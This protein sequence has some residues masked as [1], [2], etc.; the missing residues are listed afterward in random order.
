M[1]IYEYQ[2]D[3]CGH[4]LEA[5]QRIVDK[6]LRKCPDCGKAK[7]K[8]QLSAPMFLLKGSGW[9]ETD[10]KSDKENRRNLADRP[11]KEEPKAET[12][13]PAKAETKAEAKVETP[14]DSTP[15][16]KDAAKPVP[17]KKRTRPQGLRK[18]KRRRT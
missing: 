5:L 17:E 7:L 1:P 18:A 13:A 14:A 16:A 2:C 3:S 4:N 11:E 9:Y 8:R 15:E 10:F 12:A 6:P